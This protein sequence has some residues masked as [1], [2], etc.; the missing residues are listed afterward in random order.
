MTLLEVLVVISLMAVLAGS[1]ST[2]VGVAVRSKLIVATRATDTETARQTLEW[3][4]ERL[5]NAGL[6]LKP[7]DQAELRCKDMVVAQDASLRPTAGALYVSGEILNT[8][9]VAG[10]EVV[11]IG[12]FLGSDPGTG[13]QV[14]LEYQRACAGGAPAVTT[15]L[16]DP[17]ITVTSLTF[18]YYSS[19]GLQVTDLTDAAQIRS[20]RLIRVAL[21]VQGSQGQSGVQ[22]QA[23]AR[24]VML[25]NPEPNA[26]DWKNPNENI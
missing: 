19:A 12:Y 3:M 15:P 14:V 8:D 21:T 4:S 2:L 20:I 26:N 25:R 7:S 11:T 16:S 17:R 23:W 24:D 1:M 22:T 18:T 6:N 9:T 5:R 13:N 10:N